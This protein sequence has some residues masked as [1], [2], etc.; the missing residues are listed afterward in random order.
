MEYNGYFI[1]PDKT[2]YAP[3]DST[4]H[5]YIDSEKVDG[6]GESIED[7][8]KQ[9]DELTNVKMEIVEISIDFNDFKPLTIGESWILIFNF[10]K[11]IN[12]VKASKLSNVRLRQ[13]NNGSV[14]EWDNF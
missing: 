11:A 10:E 2:G 6:H 1:Y 13:N 5:F 7:C 4:Y 12:I 3:K 14:M 8:K 9:I